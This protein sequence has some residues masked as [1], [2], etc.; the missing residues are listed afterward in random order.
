M[1]SW[2][3]ILLQIMRSSFFDLWWVFRFK[4]TKHPLITG[5]CMPG[6]HC[7]LTEVQI[8]EPVF[9]DS[10]A[11]QLLHLFGT[12]TDISHNFAG[13]WTPTG[14]AIASSLYVLMPFINSAL[15]PFLYYVRNNRVSWTAVS[16]D[17]SR[18]RQT[19]S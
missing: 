10:K 18:K 8:V 11:Q 15:N 13:S 19:E 4:T 7:L 1:E 9:S 6:R 17:L 3:A 2:S 5:W 14:G 12:K 16:P